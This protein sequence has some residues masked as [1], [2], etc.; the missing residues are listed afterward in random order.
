MK[1]N[2]VQDKVAQI[3]L[4]TLVQ[5]KITTLGKP[6]QILDRP[7]VLRKTRT[8]SGNPPSGHHGIR[9][10]G[11]ECD[12]YL[13]NCSSV[14]DRLDQLT[15][16]LVLRLMSTQTRGFCG[17]WA[18]LSCRYAIPSHLRGPA[19]ES[20]L[21]EFWEHAVA[22]NVLQHPMLQVGLIDLDSKKPAW[23]QLDSVD[24]S[25]HIEW[26]VID[27]P[28]DYEE[29][30]NKNIEYQLDFKFTNLETR[31]GWRMVVR[32]LSVDNMLEVLF[33]WNHP[34][35]D[36][37]GAK[38]FH[39]TLLETLNTMEIS[40]AIKLDEET[41]KNHVL[42][43]TVTAE[44]IPPTQEATTKQRTSRDAAATAAWKENK[45]AAS[46]K[47]TFPSAEWLPI[48]SVPYATQLRTLTIDNST[49]QGALAACRAHKTTITGLLNGIAFVSLASQLPEQYLSGMTGETALDM[50]RFTPLGPPGYEWLQPD[51]SVSIFVSKMHHELD[52]S[53]VSK[54]KRLAQAASSG[55]EQMSALED[56]L[57][58]ASVAVR[59]EIKDRLDA[60]L[61]ND[62]ISMMK[63]VGDWRNYMQDATKKPRE[64]LW[65]VTN[66]GVLDGNPLATSGDHEKGWSIR[67]AKFTVC[68][69]A[70]GCFFCISAI[71]VKGGELSIDVS[72]PDN[73]ADA[74]IGEQLMSDIQS[75]LKYVKA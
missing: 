75:W 25:H 62:D 50:R 45:P 36:G 27:S 43:T 19:H 17:A 48:R 53:T 14:Q 10:R 11:R 64:S 4:S 40:T 51:K 49:L 2:I 54:V 35:L 39:Q 66:L 34:N 3:S 59:E 67:R 58:S 74:G 41:L 29:S 20:E 33:V 68:A 70:V 7:F 22:R 65:I 8:R 15:I 52:E 1:I 32:K 12:E 28:E 63:S 57:W 5:Q 18:I 60:E 26:Q 44:N 61:K 9:M 73:I 46:S 69:H 42:K 23:V 31:P 6:G 30:L 72:W 56:V 37:T 38:I 21:Q 55:Q 13:L 71:A 24:L 16:C 47:N